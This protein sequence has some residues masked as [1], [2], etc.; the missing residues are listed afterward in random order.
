MSFT[1]KFDEFLF[2][3]GTREQY[4]GDLDG[5]E[6]LPSLQ[7]SLKNRSKEQVKNW[8]LQEIYRF[9]NK[10]G[11]S[12]ICGFGTYGSYAECAVVKWNDLDWTL[13]YDTPLANDV[14]A[15]DTQESLEQ[16]LTS[17]KNLPAEA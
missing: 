12:V 7:E 13:W 14:L 1:N 17:I 9:P 6:T 8:G 2:S 3:R 4:L 10:Y 16:V 11:A 15:L 5:R